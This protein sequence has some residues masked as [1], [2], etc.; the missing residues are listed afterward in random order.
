M[1]R[2]MTYLAAA[3][4]SSVAFPALASA[5]TARVTTELNM[6]AGP[7]TGFPVVSVLPDGA[8]VDIYGCVK[9]YS[10]CDVSWQGDRGWVSANYLTHSY[11][12]DYVPIYEYGPEIDLPILAFSV[13]SYWGDYYRNEPWYGRRSHWRTVWHGPDR[14]DHRR[15]HRAEH[16]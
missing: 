15:E 5:D 9:G 1:T 6:R 10:W 8:S 2:G 4:L 3:L 12:G 13:D 7:S 16:R 14:V 11:Q